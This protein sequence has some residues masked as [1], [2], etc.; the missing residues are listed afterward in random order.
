MKKRY[1]AM[2]EDIR[3]EYF[4]NLPVRP[5]EEDDWLIDFLAMSED[6]ESGTRKSGKRYKQL[7]QENKGLRKQLQ[8]LHS[9]LL[10]LKKLL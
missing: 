6:E 5:E 4:H 2:P 1:L 8:Q 10:A 9:D 3:Y 7:Q